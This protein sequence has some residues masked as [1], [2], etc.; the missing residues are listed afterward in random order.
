MKTNK[1]ISHDILIKEQTKLWPIPDG[2]LNDVNYVTI[3]TPEDIKKIPKEGGTYWL[4][5]NEKVIL[6]FHPSSQPQNDNI[7]YNGVAQDLQKRSEQHLHRRGDA[8]QSAISLDIRTEE[9]HPK[10]HRKAAYSIKKA[11]QS[12]KD[13]KKTPYLNGKQIK[14]KQELKSLYAYLSEKECTFIKTH[15]EDIFFY[16]GINVSDLKHS[17]HIWRIYYISGI[18]DIY[19]SFIEK[20]WRNRYG[21]PKLCSYERGR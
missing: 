4:W 20:E 17:E 3:K 2:N 5:S 13:K 10:S 11:E 8:R 18:S 9:V 16:N 21:R 6:S 1:W 12:K 7:I 15:N 19:A 14:T